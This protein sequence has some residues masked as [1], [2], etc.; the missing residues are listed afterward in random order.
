MQG[1]DGRERYCYPAALPARRRGRGPLPLRIPAAAR[2]GRGKVSPRRRATSRCPTSRSAGVEEIEH[3]GPVAIATRRAS[4]WTC[5]AT[6]AGG[7]APCAR[8]PGSSVEDGR[9]PAADAA[10]GR[11]AGR[12]SAP[13]RRV[14]CATGASSGSW[15]TS[16]PEVPR[17]SSRRRS[18]TSAGP[19]SFGRTRRPAPARTR[20]SLVL[21]G[22]VVICHYAGRAEFRRRDGKPRRGRRGLSGHVL[23]YRSRDGAGA[24]ASTDRSGARSG[25]PPGPRPELTQPKPSALDLWGRSGPK[26]AGSFVQASRRISLKITDIQVEGYERV[27]RC[28]DAESGLKAIISVHDTTL[29]PALGGLRMWS[30]LSDQEA[31]TDVNRLAQGMTYKS[32]GRGDRAGRRQVRDH[33]QR[34]DRQVP[35]GPVPRDGA[36]RER[37][38]D[39]LYTTAE[40]VG[41][42]VDDMVIVRE[43][44]RGTSRDCRAR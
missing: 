33:R 28:D 43:R 35:R 36:L 14:R 2:S 40:D 16:A 26:V 20:L 44:D 12:R 29:G 31:L 19:R 37:A 10:R 22:Q 5:A 1:T 3:G 41:T 38:L 42:T 8:S 4:C 39:G 6:P 15:S 23:V 25:D 9:F 24:R 13:P 11:R 21:P 34:Q 18:R 30:Y 32:R 7:S 17:S 27:V